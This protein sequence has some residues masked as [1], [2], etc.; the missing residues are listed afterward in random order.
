MLKQHEI[1]I[2]VRYQETDAMGVLHHAN[3]FTY[4]EMG[5]VELLRASGGD[6]RKLE[7]EGIRMM[8][9]TVECRFR[10]PARFDDLLTL[11]TQV[12]RVTQAKIEHEYEL[13]RDSEV[14]ALGRTTLACVDREGKA[15]RVPDWVRSTEQVRAA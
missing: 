9:V 10:V 6:Y 12:A 5:R 15:C 14:L 4:F 11:R 13:M 8:V 1:Q 2:R 7:E 3:Y